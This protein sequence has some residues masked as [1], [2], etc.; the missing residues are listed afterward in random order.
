MLCSC[1]E[2]AEKVVVLA[3]RR[4]SMGRAASWRVWERSWTVVVVVVVVVV[5]ELLLLVVVVV[6][7]RRGR[8]G[9]G[10]DGLGAVGREGVSLGWGG[11]GG[12]RFGKER[13]SGSKEKSTEVAGSRTVG[14]FG[15]S[16]CFPF[17]RHCEVGCLFAR[18]DGGVAFKGG[19]RELRKLVSL[20]GAGGRQGLQL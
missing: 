3:R 20:G 4:A 7:V 8:E 6:V 5:E 11:L 13:K 12:H 15:L 14:C 10:G 17:G 2:R 18:E 9:V 1:G 19:D 16:G